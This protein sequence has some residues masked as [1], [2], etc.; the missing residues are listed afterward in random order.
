MRLCGDFGGE[1]YTRYWRSAAKGGTAPANPIFEVL[2]VNPPNVELDRY[3]RS[4]AKGGT[5]HAEVGGEYVRK[6]GEKLLGATLPGKTVSKCE[7]IEDSKSPSSSSPPSSSFFV[8]VL[9]FP[10]L[11]G[12]LPF[13]FSIACYEDML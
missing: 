11:P 10:F 3:W 1:P 9:L 8:S 13:F 2:V 7:R 4:A 6:M 5:F 12:C